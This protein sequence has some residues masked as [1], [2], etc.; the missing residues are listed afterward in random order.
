MQNPVFCL[1]LPH[2]LG[3][4]ELRQTLDYNAVDEN[5][6]EAHSDHK[7]GSPALD[8]YILDLLERAKRLVER[9][10]HYIAESEKLEKISHELLDRF[11]SR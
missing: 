11:L 3:F 4:H 8:R 10:K 2:F 6:M 5:S 9:S 1:A 7:P